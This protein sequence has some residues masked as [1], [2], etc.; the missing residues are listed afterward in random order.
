[1]ICIY[2]KKTIKGNFDNNGL[3]VLNELIVGEVTEE[4]NGQYYLEIEYPANSKKSIYF[5]EFNIIKADEQL[6]RIYK[7]E[8][9]QD[10]DKRI[11]V[12]ANH[13]YYDLANY[14]IEDERPTNASVKT[15]MQKAMISDLPTI[16][17]VD[18]DI[19]IAN[20]LYMV[21]MSPAE[22]MFKIIDRWGQG[23]LIRDN[24]DIKILKQRG[25]DNGVL[26]K[27]GKNI[28]GLKITI[29]TTNVVTKLYPKGANGIKLTEKYI[30]VLNWD[31]DLYPPF[32]IIKKVELKEA[33][34]EVTLRKMASELAETIGLSS[35]NIQVDFIELSKSNEYSKFKDLEKVNIGDIVT[36]RHREFNI[37]VKVKVIK[38][39]K[40]LL[41]G[42][43]TKVELGQPLGNFLKSIDPSAIIKTATDELGNQVAKVLTS[44]M[45]YANPIILNISTT[46]IQPMYLGVSAVANTNLSLNLAISCNASSECTLT[47]KIELDNVEIVFKPKQKLKQGDNVI[48]IPLGI[49]QVNQ[50]AHYVGIYLK[51]DTGTVTIPIYNMQCM[52]D[53][54]NL[55]G[56]LS[57]EPAH[58]ECFEKIEIIDINKLYIN[59][60]NHY[61]RDINLQETSTKLFTSSIGFDTTEIIGEKEIF[62]EVNITME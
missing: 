23:E 62:T 6:F 47:I 11:K 8:K 53:G 36:V 41:T 15:A 3:G 2:D 50:G 28:N 27:Y 12:Y 40:D 48:G 16:Y 33:A 49:P 46:E 24:Y 21:E 31:S 22:A 59:K 13:I 34:D 60:V 14:F 52:I 58:A 25:K 10:I 55:Q 7:V 1:M 39:K 37:D 4:L 45:Y 57:A 56:G 61:F 44:M 38:V 17:T 35:I 19:I 9:V 30:N 26:I 54:R 18:S 20:T 42:I 29:D 51:V 5:K 43:N 32:P